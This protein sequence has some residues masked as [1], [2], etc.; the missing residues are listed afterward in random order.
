M[1]SIT[2]VFSAVLALLGLSTGLLAQDKPLYNVNLIPSNLLDGAYAVTRIEEQSFT[3]MSEAKG[4]FKVLKAYTILNEKADYLCT[5]VVNYDDIWRLNYLKGTLYDAK[6]NKIRTLKKSDLIDRL[7]FDGFTFVSDIRLKIADLTYSNYPF[8]V[9]FEYEILYD[10]LMFYPSWYPQT[11]NEVS[12]QKSSM[13]VF[14]PQNFPIRYQ[15]QN[16]P[17][18]TQATEV[19]EPRKGS[20]IE[21]VRKT[22]QDK[23]DVYSWEVKNLGTYT[24]EQFAPSFLRRIPAVYLAPH[25]FVFGKYEGVSTTWKDIGLYQAKLNEGR[26][27]LPETTI[28]KVS[29][30][31]SGIEDTREKVKKI[32][33]YVQ[34]RTRYV[35][36]QLGIG[37]WQPFKASF[38]DEKGY[39]DCK[40]LTNYT[41]SLLKSQGIESFYTLVKA[42]AN[43]TPIL[44]DFPKMQF[45]HVFLSVPLE[46]DTI[47]LECTSQT[48]PFNYL[49]SFTSDRDVLLI[50]PEGGKLVHTPQYGKEV[51]I[52][53]HKASFTLDAQ[54]NA[55]A[56]VTIKGQALCEEW[57]ERASQLNGDKQEKLILDRLNIPTSFKLQKY[58][59]YRVKDE[60]P[61]SILEANIL[62]DRVASRSGKRMFLIPNVLN[63]Q[64]W[65]PKEGEGRKNPLVIEGSLERQ[66]L[67]TLQFNIPEGFSV[68][69][70][71]E[72]LELKN[73]FG[74][75]QGDFVQE[76]QTLYLYRK[77]VL[78]KGTY[79][80]EKYQEF[81]DFFKKVSKFDKSKIVL[82]A[83][84]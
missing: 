66:E 50:T 69:Y 13:K 59:A 54:G 24:H 72:S 83:A 61:S 45:N 82:L 23:Q 39:G 35:G 79:P 30:M 26:D 16:F 9:E 41:H 55:Q 29:K 78:T 4:K 21:M 48:A 47:W 44:S 80:A 63:Q 70:I 7:S 60:I 37:G 19:P 8:T 46:K 6:G 40:A 49:G 20:Q 33:G 15:E 42:G 2:T 27:Q 68:E 76:G 31:L 77:F 57:L 5:E 74:S 84:Q 73:A 38:V 43:T 53:S 34:S 71:P 32:Y 12:V 81:V 14:A 28:S 36:I 52:L 18:N 56:Q 75:F 10:G 3:I 65:I 51:N 64:S 1:K 25:K 58:K 11:D 62:I 17:S 22:V 67:D